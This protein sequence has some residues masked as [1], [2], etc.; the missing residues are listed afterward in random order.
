[1]INDKKVLNDIKDDVLKLNVCKE[2]LVYDNQVCTSI[3]EAIDIIKRFQMCRKDAMQF[4]LFLPLLSLMTFSCCKLLV[5]SSMIGVMGATLIFTTVASVYTIPLVIDI[6]DLKKFREKL[7][8]TG[9]IDS[10]S[11]KDLDIKKNELESKY[12]KVQS[13]VNSL[14]E[15]ITEL[16][17]KIHN[18]LVD[19]IIKMDEDTNNVECQYKNFINESVDYRNTHLVLNESEKEEVKKLT[20]SYGKN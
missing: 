15:T 9:Y 10:F 2:Q 8:G 3:K 7:V 19:N 1:M 5:A 18:Y 12:S 17:D 4:L 6:V 20:K 14:E 16:S 11:K 13:D